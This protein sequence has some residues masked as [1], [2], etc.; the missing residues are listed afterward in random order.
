MMGKPKIILKSV[1]KYYDAYTCALSNIDLTISEGEWVSIIGPSGSGKTTLLNMMS[2]LDTPTS[3]TINING[4]DLTGLGQKMLAKFR[5]ENVGLIFQQ[6]HLIPYL[7][8]LENVMTAQYFHGKVDREI[9]REALERMGLG[10]RLKHRPAQLSGGEQQRVCIAR[11]LINDPEIILADE[12]TGNLDMKNGEIVMGIIKQLV[13]EGRTLVIV[14]HNMDIA[15]QGRRTIQLVDGKISTDSSR[16]TH[17][18]LETSV[19]RKA[20]SPPTSTGS[21]RR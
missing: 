15:K 17:N 10:Q 14:T 16:Q 2:G 7:D 6:H 19:G 12:P 18:P 1:T 5:R 20:N 3:G 13:D 8:A 11:A 9:A 4:T 21:A